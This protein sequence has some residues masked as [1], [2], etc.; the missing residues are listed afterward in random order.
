MLIR[1]SVAASHR[2]LLRSQTY[3]TIAEILSNQPINE[4]KP[5]DWNDAKPFHAIPG[6]KPLPIIGNMH[7]LGE[8][9][10]DNFDFIKF[11]KRYEM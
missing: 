7:R 10:A 9:H 6:P 11:A 2:H 3:A 5:L 4:E 8:F 1:R